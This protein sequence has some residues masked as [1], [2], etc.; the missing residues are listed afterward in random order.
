MRKTT[1]NTTSKIGL[2][3]TWDVLKSQQPFVV[4]FQLC[5]INFNMGCFEIKYGE[6]HS[7]RHRKINFNMGCFE[8]KYYKA[9][10][11]NDQD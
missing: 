11:Q 8:M 7:Y 10:I 4:F 6:K 9:T 2:T 5:V 1:G 3:L